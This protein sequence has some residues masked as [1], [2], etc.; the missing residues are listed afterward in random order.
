MININININKEKISSP[1]K[2]LDYSLTN[3]EER[4]ELVKQIVSETPP[5]QLTNKTLEILSNYILSAITKEERKEKKILTDNRMVTINKMEIS[6]QGLSEQFENG[7]DGLYNKI[8]NDKNIL[9]TPKISITQKDLEEIPELKEL[10][11]SIEI[12]EEKQKKAKGK[13]KYLLKKQLIEMRKD[14]YIIKNSYKKPINFVNSVNAINNF[15]FIDLNEDI[16]IESNNE[17]ISS[18]GIIN[19]FNPEHISILLCNYSKLKEDSWGKFWTDSYFLMEDLDLLIENSLKEE[20]P[21]YY[22]L[23]IYKIDGKKNLEIQQLLDDKYKI[24][25]S[26][27]YISFLWRNKIPKIISKKAQE[28]YLIWYYTKKENKKAKWKRCSMCKKNK[29]A[30]NYFFSKN[31]TSRDGLYSICKDCC[32]KKAKERRK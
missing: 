29:L 11:N 22:D 2:K 19:F 25:H 26:I 17:K 28:E 5:E 24:K 7:E 12:I 9:L 21:L 31:K 3:P 16:K 23:L 18:N 32:N 20:F 1:L 4:N 27:E 8:I 10:K 30:N 6:F 14:Q 13:E 15:S